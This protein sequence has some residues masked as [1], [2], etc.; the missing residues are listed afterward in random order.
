MICINK[1]CKK[2]IGD[3]KFCPYCGKNQTETK[4]TNRPKGTGSI[5][6]RK[7][8][9]S[10]PYTASVRVGG[11]NVSIGTFATKSQASKALAEYIRKMETLDM[12]DGIVTVEQIFRRYVEP[13]FDKL[14]ASLKKN[15]MITWH[16][17]EPLH[18]MY[19]YKVKAVDIQS[20]VNIFADEHQQ[21]SQEGKPLFLDAKGKKTLINTGVPKMVPALSK[22]SLNLIKL[23]MSKI[24]RV[25]LD[26]DWAL[27][28]YSQNIDCSTP[29]ELRNNKSRFTE[30]DLNLMFER[31]YYD[32]PG[33][34]YLDY[35]ICMCYLSFRVTEFIT[36]TKEQYFISEDGIPY[37]V[38]GMKTKAG[39]DRKVPVHPRIRHI[40][41]SCID[42]GGETIFCN[43]D[44]NTALSYNRFR[45]RFDKNMTYHGFSSVY[46]PHSC[47]RTFSTR[48]SAAGVN[49]ADLI[50]LMGHTD[51]EMDYD[52]YINQEIKTLYDA[53]LR[54]K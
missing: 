6:I 20:V 42:R 27:R 10:K 50:A 44:D 32:I 36:L 49:D 9:K 25:A 53:I 2:E 5:Y 39:I 11:K 17:I 52:H 34:N 22:G 51:I 41:E 23:L 31:M 29:T 43:K 13:S 54:V 38:A 12:A 33:G 45:Y 26:N 8:N 24:F 16:R 4:R 7:D 21:L 37:F 35:V 1:R 18:D 30:S 3:S 46:T 14:S 40:V 28:D 47:R 15:Y 19:M 48:L